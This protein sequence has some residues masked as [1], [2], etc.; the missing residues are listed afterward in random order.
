[1]APTDK[2]GQNHC[3]LILTKLPSFSE[4]D[5]IDKPV[6]LFKDIVTQIITKPKGRNAFSF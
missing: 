6:S 3:T 4:A 2:E 1:M 5:F